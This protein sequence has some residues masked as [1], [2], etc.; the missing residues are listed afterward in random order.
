MT[1]AVLI[2]AVLAFSDGDS[3][4][5][6]DV[7]IR[8]AGVDAGEV[9]PFTRCRERPDVWACSR[10]ARAH[11]QEARNLARGLARRGA[12]CRDTGERSWGRVVAVCEAGGR[13]IGAAVVR[14]GLAIADPR[15]G[16]AY[17]DEEAA[18]RRER[19]GVWR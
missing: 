17:L 15:Y 6:G 3:A 13:D 7:R 5:C 9:A 12:R 14:A 10:V 16:A 2:C 19:L 18:A 1:P 8:L 11:A 4:R